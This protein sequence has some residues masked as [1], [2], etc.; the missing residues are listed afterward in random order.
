M[1]DEVKDTNEIIRIRKSKDRQHNDQK[2]KRHND[3]Q[4]STKKIFR[5]LNLFLLIIKQNELGLILISVDMKYINI[6]LG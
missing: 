1:Q 5:K 4:L 2:K 6:K 3:K